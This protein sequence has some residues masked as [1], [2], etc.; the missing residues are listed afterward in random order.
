LVIEIEKHYT[1][2]EEPK[3]SENRSDFHQLLANVPKC[4]YTIVWVSGWHF[5]E[6][7]IRLGRG[8]RTGC[9]LPFYEIP[10]TERSFAVWQRLF[11]LQEGGDA[12]VIQ[13]GTQRAADQ[14]AD[15]GHP[16]VGHRPT[17]GR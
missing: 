14:R 10:F 13:P 2:I 1:I 6:M 12:Q 15:D 11:L 8:Q 17:T 9:P 7:L 3:L 4:N 16:E 5:D